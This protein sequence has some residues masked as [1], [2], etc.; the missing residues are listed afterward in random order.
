[1]VCGERGV[2]HELK[3]FGIHWKLLVY[4]ELSLGKWRR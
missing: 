2:G 3:G 4:V 1:V